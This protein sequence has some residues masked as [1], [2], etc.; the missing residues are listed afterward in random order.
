MLITNTQVDE[1]LVQLTDLSGLDQ[2][3]VERCSPLVRSERYDESVSRAFIVLE[4]RLRERLGVRGGAGINLAEKAFAPKS[5]QLVDNLHLPPSEVDGI[6]NLFVGAFKAFRNRAAHTVAD[7]SLDEARAIIH[8]VNLLLLT[9]EKARQPPPQRIPERIAK[10]LDPATTDRLQQF[11]QSLEQIGIGKGEG[12]TSTPYRATLECE[13]PSWEKPRH[14]PVTVLY[15]L[16]TKGKPVIAFNIGGLSQVIRLDIDQLEADLLQAECVRV[17]AKGTP[18]RL[19]LDRNTD[20]HT[21][22]RLYNIL[23]DLMEKHRI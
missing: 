5:G 20:Q 12:K 18:I 16:V 13:Y 14:H 8:L 6:R 4:E 23:Q 19:L 2:E 7:Y 21:F 11:L 3:L 17:A 1:L 9:L 22:D 15:L 10:L